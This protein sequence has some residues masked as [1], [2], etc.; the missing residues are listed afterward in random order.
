MPGG[1]G[2]WHHR[3]DTLTVP[4]T[5]DARSCSNPARS[6]ARAAARKPSR[7]PPAVLCADR[8]APLGAEGLARTARQLT[9]MRLR[10]LEHLRD[11]CVRVVECFAE[12]VDCALPRPELLEQQQDREL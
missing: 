11:V 5:S 12:H 9:G 10:E 3:G 6:T 8:L 2:S 4:T 7:P 1:D